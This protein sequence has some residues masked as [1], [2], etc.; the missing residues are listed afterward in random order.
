MYIWDSK[1]LLKF[2]YRYIAIEGCIGAGKTSF[3]KMLATKCNAKL[4]LEEFEENDFLPKFYKN[5][6]R[7]AFPLELSF[8]ASR[9]HQF[10]NN[11]INPE[12]FFDHLI[13]DYIFP[14][15]LIFSRKTLQPDEY[16]LYKKLFNI[17]YSN[18]PR[19][20]LILYLYVQ[21]QKLKENIT[22]R[23]RDYE[24]EI[25][26]EY[27]ENIQ[28]SYMDYFKEQ[29]NLRVVLANTNEMDFVHNEE[30]LLTLISLLNRDW[31][32]GISVVDP[33]NT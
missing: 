16:E 7:Y 3:A 5:P 31:T 4:I 12:L 1:M 9:F 11:V 29:S 13:S 30:H 32:T 27:L 22:A 18:L 6:D 33:L 2:P 10:K 19:P 20:D 8:L 15:S 28:Q 26:L 25:S 21:P 14:K 23:G 24:Q 17:I